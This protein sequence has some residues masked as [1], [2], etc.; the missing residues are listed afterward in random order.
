[1]YKWRK[2][3]HV[4]TRLEY[5]IYNSLCKSKWLYRHSVS[6]YN[7]HIVHDK[8]KKEKCKDLN[9]F[10]PSNGPLHTN[11]HTHTHGSKGPTLHFATLTSST[12]LHE[13]IWMLLHKLQWRAVVLLSTH[14]G[15]FCTEGDTSAAPF[16]I[17]L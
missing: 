6:L 17:G 8:K 15:Q 9:V 16:S 4:N 11:T 3:V 2:I 12:K 10:L 7:V 13:G 1:M 5:P 14:Q